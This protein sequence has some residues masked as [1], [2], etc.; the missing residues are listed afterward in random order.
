MMFYKNKISF[1]K[2]EIFIS[3][4]FIKQKKWKNIKKKI[5]T[6]FNFIWLDID[7]SWQTSDSKWLDRFCDSTKSWLDSDSTRK[8]FRWLWLEGLVTRQI[9]LV[10]ITALESRLIANSPSSNTCKASVAKSEPVT[11]VT[12]PGWLN[13]GAHASVL[14]TSAWSGPGLQCRRIHCLSLVPQHPH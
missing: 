1:E 8:K 13:M 7:S 6:M 4:F 11:D 10:H 3:F 2:K 5:M 9:W 14:R 12:S